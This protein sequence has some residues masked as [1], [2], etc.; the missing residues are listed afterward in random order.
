MTLFY[1]ALLALAT[2]IWGWVFYKK[3]YH[4]QPM[5][6]IIQSFVA[7]MLAMIP[8]FGY[9]YV[10]MH[11]LPVISEF[12]ILKPLLSSSILSG[13]LFFI[14]NM[15]IVVTLL[16]IL[17]SIIAL[18]LTRFKHQT[19]ENIRATLKDDEFEFVTMSMMI[20]LLIYGERI[21]E[22]IIDKPIVYTIVGSILFLAIIEE[23]V[24]HV[25]VR[26]IDDKKIKDIDDAITLSIIVGLAFAFLETIIYAISI[27]DMSIILPRAL[28]TIP[29]HV[30]ASGIFGY[31][32]GLAHFAKEIL[33]AE[34]KTGKLKIDFRFRWIH[35]VLSLRKRDIFEEGKTAQG[36]VLATLFHTAA[37]LLFELDLAYITVPL[38]IV[39]VTILSHMYKKSHFIYR[40]LHKR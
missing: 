28:L 4:P 17:S 33:E 13:L 29:I 8:V 15:F 1:S 20:A 30:I 36:L 31:Y 18:I 23:Y 37:N 2:F 16:T 14:L 9:R 6:V 3:E 34:H 11:Y 26:F 19:L 39:G 22:N 27:G 12:E 40:L 25:T 32:Y 35:T 38:I 21:V 10:Y 24:K 5:K 7:G